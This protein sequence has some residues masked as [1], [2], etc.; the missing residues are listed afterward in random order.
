MQ[1]HSTLENTGVRPTLQNTEA[2]VPNVGLKSKKVFNIHFIMFI[3]MIYLFC[4]F[5]KT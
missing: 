1:E 4:F 5:L 3:K 2:S